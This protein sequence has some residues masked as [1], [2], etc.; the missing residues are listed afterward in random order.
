MNHHLYLFDINGTYI[1]LK[2]KLHE[3]NRYFRLHLLPDFWR[4]R[5]S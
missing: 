3:N 2:D 5:R 4:S 1:N